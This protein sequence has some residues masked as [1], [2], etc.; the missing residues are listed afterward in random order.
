M[1]RSIG[2]LAVEHIAAG[3]VENNKVIGPMRLFPTQPRAEDEPDPLL[4]MPAESIAQAVA[5]EIEILSKGQPA[6]A[7]GVA[8]PGIIHDGVIH[9]SPNLQQIKGLNLRALLSAA[10]PN[11]PPVFLFND[12]D[13]MAAGIAATRGQL[14]RLIRVWTLGSGIG[15]GRYPWAEGIWEGGHTV[16]T[17]DPKERFCS[18]GGCGHLEGIL[19]HRSMRLRFLDLEPEEVFEHAEQGDARCVAFVKMAHRALAAATATCIH[20]EGP[21]KF[22][23]TGPN[24]RFINLS[25]LNLYL[26]E[27]VKMSPLQGSLFEVISTSDEI[28]VI[29]AAVNA[30]RMSKPVK[31]KK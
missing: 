30:E 11:S 7:V 2:V 29:G 23:V 9:E 10:L 21:G 19:G 26:H 15:F 13:A 17:L 3:V 1:R 28:G 22:F 4:G 18:C 8:F 24:A 20:M 5:R 12:A 25:L 6:T 14:D 16:V 27:M 31:V